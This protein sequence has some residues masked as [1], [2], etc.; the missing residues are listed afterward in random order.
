M[1]FSPMDLRLSNIEKIF[2]RSKNEKLRM[3]Q[4]TNIKLDFMDYW[5]R[6]VANN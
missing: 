1:N 6:Q 3:N 5:A 2:Q 4:T